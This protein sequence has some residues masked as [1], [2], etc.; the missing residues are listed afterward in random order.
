VSTDGPSYSG[1]VTYPYASC[2]ITSQPKTVYVI[3]KSGL[4]AGNY[5]SENIAISGGSASPINVACSG[6]VSVF[7][8]ECGNES[9]TNI[10]TSSSTSY[11]SRNWTGDDGLSWSATDARTDQTITGKAITIRT[12]VLTSPSSPGGIGDLSFQTKFPYSESSGTLKIKV[13]GSTVGTVV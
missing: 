10:P 9:F 7:S 2:V 8:N 11:L 13:N 1:S 4:S 3:L 5:N 12:G 6:S